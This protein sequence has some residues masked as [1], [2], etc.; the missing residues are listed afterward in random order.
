M[1]LLLVGAQAGANEA[2]LV[3]IDGVAWEVQE[4]AEWYGLDF[5]D[6]ADLVAS[7]T[8]G[9]YTVT[10]RVAATYTAGIATPGATSTFTIVAAVVPAS[11]R[12]LLRLPEG[13]RS[14]ETK[15]IY[16]AA[17]VGVCVAL[18]QRAA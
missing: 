12:D 14:T 5:L 15:T 18:A 10:R 11:G 2:D 13:R 3:A 9:T 4:S 7:F 6:V 16:V 1:P 17:G 8:T